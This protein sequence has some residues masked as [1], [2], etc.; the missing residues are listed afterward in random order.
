MIRLITFH[1]FMNITI[2]RERGD[3]PGLDFTPEMS[4]PRDAGMIR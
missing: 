1:S 4:I 2:P 3:D